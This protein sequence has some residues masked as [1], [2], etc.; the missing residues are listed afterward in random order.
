MILYLETSNLIKLYVE[1]KGTAEIKS[2]VNGA[3]I[4][5]TSIISYAE[6]RAAL[7]RKYKEGGIEKQDYKLIKR[8][9]E[10]DWNKYFIL[11]ISSDIIKA[12]G[13][14]AEKHGLRGFDALHLASALSLKERSATSVT[15]SSADRNLSKAAERENRS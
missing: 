5:A 10:S 6:A 15:F 4:V 14:L 9:F 3:D 12:A 1:E 13:D 7:S 2:F 8:E 11:H